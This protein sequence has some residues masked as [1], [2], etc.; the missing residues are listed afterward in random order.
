MSHS[1]PNHRVTSNTVTDENGR[2]RFHGAFTGGFS[3][4]YFN[5]V[6]SKEGFQPATF[7][8]SRSNRAK[9][10]KKPLTYY[11][12]EEDGLLGGT[13]YTRQGVDAFEEDRKN[14]IE[15]KQSD[16]GEDQLNLKHFF[17]DLVI[18]PSN[19]VGRRLLAKLGWKY[20]HSVGPR[21][22]C[23]KDLIPTRVSRSALDE[24]GCITFVKREDEKMKEIFSIPVFKYDSNGLGYN[25]NEEEDQIL[26]DFQGRKNNLISG[27]DEEVDNIYDYGDPEQSYDNEIDIRTV[28][29]ADVNNNV[30]KK[31]D[32]WLGKR[33]ND[34]MAKCS[35]GKRPLQGFV[36]SQRVDFKPLH[37]NIEP[38]PANFKSH[39]FFTEAEK[40][41]IIAQNNVQRSNLKSSTKRIEMRSRLMEKIK[42]SILPST[43]RDLPA[44]DSSSQVTHHNGERPMLTS[45][46]VLN[47][48]LAGMAEALKSRF[49]D[50]SS[51]SHTQIDS[52]FK[53]G[54]TKIEDI[55]Q[56]PSQTEANTVT[57]RE[58]IF[59]LC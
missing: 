3:A 46:T 34:T 44:S 19:T 11:A 8:S 35:D 23:H 39:H 14:K 25:I 6:G 52:D 57:G 58:C 21:R 2:R 36:L 55:K 43:N 22:A 51:V 41:C 38:V 24:N 1:R 12:D 15:T 26:K 42:P 59:F 30:N 28:S 16:Q 54:L 45:S 10:E 33:G 40:T 47:S 9:V 53:A 13:L 48:A 32:N 31:V 20:G 56:R 29:H 50:N 7:I 5:T 4:G 27:L 18:L 37:F 49:M 17:D